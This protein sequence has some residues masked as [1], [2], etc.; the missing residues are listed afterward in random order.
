MARPKRALFASTG[1]KISQKS[2]VFAA[3]SVRYGEYNDSDPVLSVAE[4]RALMND[5]FTPDERIK[6]RI[7]YLTRYTRKII[8]MELEKLC[9]K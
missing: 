9:Q 8:K 5:Y 6:E 7:D 4:Y 2:A 3:E 1:A